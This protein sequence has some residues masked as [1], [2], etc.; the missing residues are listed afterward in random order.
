LIVLIIAIVMSKTVAKRFDPTD[1]R[2][3]LVA[4]IP[5]AHGPDDW[6]HI[7]TY[8][9]TTVKDPS[10][11]ARKRAKRDPEG[12]FHDATVNEP[13]ERTKERVDS[14]LEDFIDGEMDTA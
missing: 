9:D 4:Y 3:L 8:D 6:E 5:K 7:V 13:L 1:I 12:S 2:P 11:S 10:E 14:K